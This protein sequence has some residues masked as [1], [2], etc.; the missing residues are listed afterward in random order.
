[1][2]VISI[3]NACLV[4]EKMQNQSCKLAE[5]LEL[6]RGRYWECRKSHC[7]GCRDVGQDSTCDFPTQSKTVPCWSCK[8]GCWAE[9][10]SS[11]ALSGGIVR[12]TEP[13]PWVLLKSPCLGPQEPQACVSQG[14]IPSHLSCLCS[15]AAPPP[16]WRCGRSHIHGSRQ[17][18]PRAVHVGHR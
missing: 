9:S 14:K 6:T 11:Q 4:N 13:S 8:W 16:Q 12:G 10:R 17:L 7:Q 5:I 1:M 3:C 18:G 2:C 15:H